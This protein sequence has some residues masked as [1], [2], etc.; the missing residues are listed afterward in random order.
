MNGPPR[1]VTNAREWAAY[2]GIIPWYAAATGGPRISVT[3][4]GG[5]GATSYEVALPT[6]PAGA[7]AIQIIVFRGGSTADYSVTDASPAFAEVAERDSTGVSAIYARKAT[8]A[9]SS[10]ADIAVSTTRNVAWIALTLTGMESAGDIADLVAAAFT[11][12]NSLNPPSLTPGWDGR[13]FTVAS[14][15]R[16]DNELVP[17]TGFE[18]LETAESASASSNT[19]DGR[20]S[21]AVG[22]QGASVDPATWTNTG[23]VANTHS[24]TFMVRLPAA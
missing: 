19:A 1:P 4:G 23:D 14:T 22:G 15:R 20:V 2:L 10:T 11:G 12:S 13:F 8:D 17:P 5:Q 6:V 9:A 21:V 7:D 3:T 24:A 18:L 16:T